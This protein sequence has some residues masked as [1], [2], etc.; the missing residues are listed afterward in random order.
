MAG[1]ATDLRIKPV[2]V[3]LLNGQVGKLPSKCLVYSPLTQTA[4]NPV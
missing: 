2:I 4:L 1:E 3:I